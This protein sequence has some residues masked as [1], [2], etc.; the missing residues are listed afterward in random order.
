MHPCLRIPELIDLIFSHL[1]PSIWGRP[2][3]DSTALA[4][5]A[6]TCTILS[7]R[8]LD[9][10]WRK[11]TDLVNLLRCMPSDVWM[12]STV[13]GRGSMMLLTRPILARDWDRPLFYTHRVKV[14]DSLASGVSSISLLEFFPALSLSLPTDCVFPNLTRLYWGPRSGGDVDFQYIRLFLSTPLRSIDISSTVS[15]SSL[16]LLAA[17]PLKCRALQ[18]V[19]IRIEF[20]HWATQSCL[21][22]FVQALLVVE[23]LRMYLPDLAA[24]QHVGRLATL[25]TLE[26]PTLP[27]ALSSALPAERNLFRNLRYLTIGTI[28]LE[29][30]AMSL[31]RMCATTSFH[32]LALTFAHPPTAETAYVFYSVL[33][34]CRNS[35][36]SLREL[37][38]AYTE[39][40]EEDLGT[41]L[42]YMFAPPALSVLYCFG[43]LTGINICSLFGF[44]LDDAA[45]EQMARAWPRIQTLELEESHSPAHQ[46]ATIGCLRAL[47]RHCPHLESLHMTFDASVVPPHPPP[48]PPASAAAPHDRLRYLYVAHSRIAHPERVAQFIASIFTDVKHLATYRVGIAGDAAEI[49]RRQRWKEAE[50]LLCPASE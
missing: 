12:I 1:K 37:M 20:V 31:L 4:A 10:L 15:S 17:L 27:P 14:F 39:P 8:A 40:E 28:Q 5:L 42:G 2:N 48:D 11:Q 3:P 44:D 43:N 13:P 49:A 29:R 50:L 33:A 6:R 46:R 26:I 23:D 45:V 47:G 38:L 9:V 16:S 41:A 22:E 34:Q 25:R 30:A 19:S 18:S 24:L 32:F 36:F 7:S 21:S 35:H